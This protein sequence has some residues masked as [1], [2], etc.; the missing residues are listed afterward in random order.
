MSN[1]EA[2]FESEDFQMFI[3]E[4]EEIISDISTEVYGFSKVLKA[5][6]L[7][8]PDEF[9]GETLIDTQKNIRVFAE[10]ATAQYITEI[11]SINGSMLAS[12]IMQEGEVVNSSLGDYL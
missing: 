3:S 5:F 2:L 11:C 1:L 4:A 7:N 12:E 9:L 8:H 10:I 6:A